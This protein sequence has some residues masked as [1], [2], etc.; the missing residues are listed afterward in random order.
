[1]NEL[2]IYYAPS[3]QKNKVCPWVSRQ[4][5]MNYSTCAR[6]GQTYHPFWI[7]GASIPSF[8]INPELTHQTRT[9]HQDFRLLIRV[10]A[11]INNSNPKLLNVALDFMPGSL[12]GPFLAQV[13]HCRQQLA[14]LSGLEKSL[15]IGLR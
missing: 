2:S 1:V 9:N 11:L 4:N 5:P 13:S 3:H 10:H 6:F 15:Q 14:E 7:A 8:L 12:L